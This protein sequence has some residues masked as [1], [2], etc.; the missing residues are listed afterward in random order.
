MAELGRNAAPPVGRW[1]ALGSA[2]AAQRGWLRLY[3]WLWVLLCVAGALFAAAPRVLSQPV[4]YHASAETRF[5]TGRYGGLYSEAWPGAG[6]SGLDV[7]IADA[8]ETLRRIAQ[9]H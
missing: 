2:L 9:S 4:V 1:Q 3:Q 6:R 5:D 7:A 8:T